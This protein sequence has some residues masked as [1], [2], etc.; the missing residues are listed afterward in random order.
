MKEQRE[1]ARDARKN[2]GADAW[3]GE[4]NVLEGLPATEFVG[5]ETMSCK[6]KV[7]AIV[8]DGQRADSVVGG[9]EAVLEIGR[10]SCRERV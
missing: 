6:A 5:Y 10:A 4:S 1:R 9:E 3:E 2:A 7:L 8:K